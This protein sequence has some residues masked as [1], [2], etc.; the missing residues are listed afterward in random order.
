MDA[1]RDLFMKTQ[2]QL[3]ADQLRNQ[4]R[5][6]HVC[7]LAL[8]VVEL[9]FRQEIEQLLF[10]RS[11]VC[12]VQGRDLHNVVKVSPKITVRIDVVLRLALVDF[13]DGEDFL[14]A[15]ATDQPKSHFLLV[16]GFSCRVNDIHKDINALQGVFDDSKEFLCKDIAFLKNAGR[17]QEHNLAALFRENATHGASCCLGL[18]GRDGDFGTD[19]IVEK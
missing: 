3:F 7:D 10:E 11:Q 9:A 4:K 12:A 6:R 1:V 8:G 2:K 15:R 13:I 19:K 17:V 14:G 18:G 16:T 5:I